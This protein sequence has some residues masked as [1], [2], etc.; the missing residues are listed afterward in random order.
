M[1]NAQI[2]VLVIAVVSLML[3]ALNVYVLWQLQQ[4]QQS[5]TEFD[6]Q[7][8]RSQLYTGDALNDYLLLDNANLQKALARSH[9]YQVGLSKELDIKV[10]E[11]HDYAT[12][13]GQLQ[14]LLS[15]NEWNSD[16]MQPVFDT[17]EQIG[18]PVAPMEED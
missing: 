7:L 6:N 10:E 16:L 2:T 9:S 11:L 14:Q 17:L 1:N 3:V 12:A 4:Q 5:D 18:F 15:D 13:L 8:M